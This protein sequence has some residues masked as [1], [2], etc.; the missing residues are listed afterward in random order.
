M[1]KPNIPIQV[2]VWST[3]QIIETIRDDYPHIVDDVLKDY[4]KVTIQKVLQNL[5]KEGI[6]IR[7]LFVQIGLDVDEK[8]LTDFDNRLGT[9]KTIK[10]KKIKLSTNLPAGYPNIVINSIP[11]L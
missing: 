1:F 5:L 7:D 8:A 4:S 9:T 2:S 6:P 10:G 11:T 3:N